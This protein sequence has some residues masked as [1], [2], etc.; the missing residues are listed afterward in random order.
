MHNEHRC[1][2]KRILKNIFSLPALLMAIFYLCSFFA[3]EH[4]YF[5][6]FR[7]FILQYFIL[8]LL[9]ICIFI[10]TRAI[11]ITFI[12][13]LVLFG[14]GYELLTTTHQVL[15]T[16]KNE[17]K[18]IKIATYN[19]LYSNKNF[20]SLLT[21]IQTEAPDILI[22]Q[23]TQNDIS[24]FMEKQRTLYP[25]QIHSPRS[26]AFGMIIASKFPF[27]KQEVVSTNSLVFDNF[28]IHTNIQ[29]EQN[30]Q[31]SLYAI[32]PPPPVS[33]LYE[34]QRNEDLKSISEKITVD[35]SDNIIM[36][37]DWN[38]T[39][40]SPY[41][42]ELLKETHMRNEYTSLLPTRT[43]PTKSALILWQ[44]PIDHILSKGKVVLIDKYPGLISD[45][46]H[47]PLVAKFSIE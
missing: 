2:F 1:A 32:H 17:S 27:E 33:A 13:T 5:D 40:Y 15:N 38:I 34:N 45:S 43:W 4:F 3:K 26:D 8:S 21:W 18:I 44:I 24:A 46:D 16:L 39:P 20:N 14:T 12:M 25:Y 37:G 30:K 31:I 29:I 41:F 47:F 6:I 19:K 35:K 11:L 7:H 28:F 10:W 42:K 36:A 23:E 22:L 9:F